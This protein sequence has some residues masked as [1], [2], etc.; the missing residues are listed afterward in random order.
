MTKAQLTDIAVTNGLTFKEI[1]K[2]IILKSE[3]LHAEKFDANTTKE[4]EFNWDMSSPEL[5]M[6]TAMELKG[7]VAFNLTKV[8]VTEK[9]WAMPLDMGPIAFINGCDDNDV[10]CAIVE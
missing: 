7:L 8:S 3:I 1:I 5:N 2:L 6:Y 10:L 9:G 4:I